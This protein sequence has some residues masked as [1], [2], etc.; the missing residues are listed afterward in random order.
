MTPEAIHLEL[1]APSLGLEAHVHTRPMSQEQLKAITTQ[2]CICSSL[3]VDALCQQRE[4][5]ISFVVLLG[6][7]FQAEASALGEPVIEGAEVQCSLKGLDLFPL[8][9]MGSSSEPHQLAS[10]QHSRLKLNGEVT[11]SGRVERADDHSEAF[12]GRPVVAACF[13]WDVPCAAPD[14]S[15]CALP[16][17]VKSP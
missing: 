3:Q 15:R 1:S 6:C 9:S 17:Q 16:P 10:G 8:A 12:A 13:A 7:F 11:M 14:V 2:A 5:F 4:G